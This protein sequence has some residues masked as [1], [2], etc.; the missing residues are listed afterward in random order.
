[1]IF[2]LINGLFLILL[3]VAPS[4]AS[5]HSDY[6]SGSYTDARSVTSDCLSCHQ[7]QGAD[8]METAHWLWKGP[9]PFVMGHENDTGI[10]KESLMN[11]F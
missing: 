2:R 8:F 9:T 3:F 5:D 7:D 4:W 1:M 10:G 6:V 11:N